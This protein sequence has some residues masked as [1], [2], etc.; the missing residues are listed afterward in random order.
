[1]MRLFLALAVVMAAMSFETDPVRA[2]EAPW[3]AVVSSGPGS[4][5]WDCRYRTVEE[6][7]PNVIAGNRGFCNQNPRYVGEL[8]PVHKYET[9]RRRGVRKD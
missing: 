2:S 4:V 8:G 5:Y 3:C 6:C 9:H 7:V 1:M